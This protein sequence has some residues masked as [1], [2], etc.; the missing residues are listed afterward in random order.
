M[1][2]LIG[3]AASDC[4]KN[5]AAAG[6]LP[7][8]IS[9]MI[10]NIKLYHILIDS[11][12]APNLISMAAFQK[13]HISMSKLAPSCLFS[14]VDPGSIIP[15]GSISLS[16]TFRTPEHY[17][18][19]SRPALYQFMAIAH[20]SYMVLKMSLPNGIIKIRRDRTAGTFT[21]AHEAAAGLNE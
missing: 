1:E 4:P 14:R 21:L 19:L 5:M 15:R 16:V 17:R 13:L 9:P 12:A 20:Y 18:I 8:V 6:Q 11:G 7:L 2:M 3:F 10:A